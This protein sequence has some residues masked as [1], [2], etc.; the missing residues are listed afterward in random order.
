MHAKVGWSLAFGLLLSLVWLGGAYA[1]ASLS[2]KVGD[3]F[4]I[5][6][7]G[8][9]IRQFP[10][11]TAFGD[12]LF[13]TYS[14]NTDVIT[15]QPQSGSKVSRDGGITW[16]EERLGAAGQIAPGLLIKLA[17]G[18]LIGFSFAHTRTGT[19]TS[20]FDK[21]TS[22]DNGL[23]WSTATATLTLPYDQYAFPAYPFR[24]AMSN[25]DYMLMPDGTLR[26]AMYGKY[27][28]DS[29]NRVLWAQ[30][31]DG[32]ISWSVTST[33]AYTPGIGPEGY[34]EV[35]VERVADHSLLAVMRV[36]QFTPLYQS[37][38]SDNGLTWSVPTPLPGIDKS[39]TKSVMPAL[40]NLSNGT[41]ALVFGRPGGAML[42]S[43]DGSGYEWGHY[44]PIYTDLTSGYLGIAEVAP[45]RL[46]VVGDRGTDWQGATD[47]EIWGKF[48]D[49]G[50][51]N[52]SGAKIDLMAKYARG[53]MMVVTDLVY[54]DGSVPGASVSAAFDG[55]TQ[56]GY[57]AMKPTTATPG[58]YTLA[59]DR[60]YP[61]T[62]LGIALHPVDAE[63]ADIYFSTDGVNWG[64]PVKSYTN[65]LHPAVD[66][67]TFGAPI[68]A[69]Y[70]RVNVTGAGGGV[71]AL[72]EIE[73]YY[74]PDGFE[75]DTTG[76][77]P[78]GYTLFSGT[79][80]TSA[81]RAYAG[82]KS[83]R[84]YDTSAT[85]LSDIR[86]TTTPSQAK[87]LAFQ[88]YPAATAVGHSFDIMSG[89]TAAYH[90]AIFNDG[91]LK[92]YNGTTW[93]LL[94]DSVK[95]T[96]NQWNAIRIDASSARARVYV[97][98][99][100]AGLAGRVNMASAA[101]DGFRFAS[102]GTATV[103]D[104]FYIDEL[105]FETDYNFDE[106]TFE[107]DPVGALPTG[108][109][110]SRQSGETAVVSDTVAYGGV[111][112]L[113][114]QDQVTD[115]IS[116]FKKVAEPSPTKVWEFRLYPQS[117]ANGVIFDIFGGTGSEAV[118]HLALFNNGQLKFYNGSSWVTLSTTVTVAFNQWNK[119]TVLADM[120][121]AKVYRDGILVGTAGKNGSPA[122]KTMGGFR[123]GTGSTAGTGDA[124]YVDDVYFERGY[125]NDLDTFENDATGSAPL[126]YTAAMAA[127]GTARATEGTK[128]LRLYDTTSTAQ[129]VAAKSVGRSGTKTVS[130]DLY[131]AAV[132]YGA[133]FD[134]KGN[135]AAIYHFSINSAGALRY[136]NGSS[137][138]ALT[139]AGP[140]TIGA[141]NHVRVEAS[142]RSADV[143][144]N[145]VFAG[146]AG[147]WNT[148]ETDFDGIAFTS[149][150]TAGTGD[151]FY[152]DNVMVMN[153]E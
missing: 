2:V 73:L 120:T 82:S 69:R 102:S 55:D 14:A 107:H 84:I 91:S 113:Y 6:D 36:G 152:V 149:G 33:I 85:T 97:G 98:G 112:S 137:W 118:Y 16:G 103:G 96:V 64:S 89:N 8:N 101:F 131:P 15:D 151:D 147:R 94:S 81:A 75:N 114:L 132:P 77:V 17:N 44:T 49:V 105:T 76:S 63:S 32:G 41:L 19:R 115:A 144:L 20:T 67:T 48:V 128:S 43:E 29:S 27:A 9:G 50:K 51:T 88:Y 92:W 59:L 39:L 74:K 70:V 18:N 90:L 62:A 145:G 80:E 141:W 136:Y 104:D 153:E 83:L 109:G 127:V 93:N 142:D 68:A 60:A 4:V 86:R 40:V 100:L 38:S 56:Y 108:L 13:I 129:A 130:F 110:Y 148:T 123:F 52:V 99:K 150:A 119:V 45:N 111:K 7:G 35:A 134:L 143:Y 124:F 53:D 79:A 12:D 25:T 135:N 28:T 23:T 46:L 95:A 42:F 125:T 58:Q 10:G 1:A 139:G 65:A 34:D 61:V 106:D 140:A 71:P 78:A 26:L 57:A 122:A 5:E 22:T 47:Y 31:T 133:M 146:T 121:E 87:V 24:G 37:R 11:L 54:T 66:I 138:I 3:E 72:H 30:S 21:Y 117:V 116:A 126:G